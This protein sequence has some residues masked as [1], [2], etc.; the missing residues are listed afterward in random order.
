[1]KGEWEVF[2]GGEGEREDGGERGWRG[3]GGG[4]CMPTTTYYEA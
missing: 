2:G 1:M 3:G 4:Y